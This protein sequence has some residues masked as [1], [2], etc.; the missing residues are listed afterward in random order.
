MVYLIVATITAEAATLLSGSLSFYSY[1]MVMITVAAIPAAAIPA[2]VLV[3]FSAVAMMAAV[4]S[5]L[6]Y[7]SFAA[8]AVILSSSFIDISPPKAIGYFNSQSSFVSSS[9]EPDV[10]IRSGDII[11]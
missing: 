1:V 9:D 11:E 4:V 6:S 8:A 3:I 10:H 5:S 2:L 7:C